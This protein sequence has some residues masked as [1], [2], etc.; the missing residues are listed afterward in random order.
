VNVLYS[1]DTNPSFNTRNLL[2][3]T[4]GKLW[5]ATSYNG[6]WRQNSE[7]NWLNYTTAN[8]LANNWIYDIIEVNAALGAETWAA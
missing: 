7:G 8:G 2:L 1:F 3:S 4:D 6:I 5:I